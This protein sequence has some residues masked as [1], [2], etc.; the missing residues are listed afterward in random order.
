MTLNPVIAVFHI[1]QLTRRRIMSNAT[2]IGNN[3]VTEA[4]VFQVPSV[5]FT[6]TF[7][8]FHHK[9]VIDAVRTGIN[10]VGLEVVK[11][12]Y[13]LAGNEGVRMFGVWYLATGRLFNIITPKAYD[14][15]FM[16]SFHK[17]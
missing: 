17:R 6:R 5:P 13:V 10:A 4:E 8:P 15:G 7:K 16:Y 2:L 9:Q 14:K 12:E 11:T 1:N 3:R